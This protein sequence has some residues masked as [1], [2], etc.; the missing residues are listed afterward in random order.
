[1]RTGMDAKYDEAPPVPSWL[2]GH[3]SQLQDNV[4]QLDGAIERVDRLLN[5]I[6]GPVP[7]KGVNG[8]KVSPLREALR[9]RA[10]KM[11]TDQQDRLSIL[12]EKLRELE[13]LVG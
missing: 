5:R 4:L 10:N 11:A 6:R 8:E 12:F 9:D 7:E 1:M 2:D 3:C 13:T